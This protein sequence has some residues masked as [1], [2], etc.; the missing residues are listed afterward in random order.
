MIDFMIIDLSFR[1][2]DNPP[3]L[4]LKKEQKT[5]LNS[6]LRKQHYKYFNT[7]V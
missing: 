6:F 4:G 3:F 1:I 5:S 2:A 7:F